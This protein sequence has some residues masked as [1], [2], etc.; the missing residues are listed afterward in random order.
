MYRAV[1]LYI[2]QN[3]IEL[4]DTEA[5]K[6]MLDHIKIDLIPSRQRFRIDLGGVD[7]TERITH[8][9]VSSQVSEVAALS[10]VRKRMVH[11]QQEIGKNKGV[12]MDGRDIGTVVYPAAELKLF[13][14]ANTEIRAMRRY[15]ELKA[16]NIEGS[17]D[18]I[19][20]NLSHRD[21]IDSTRL[22]SPLRQATDAVL[23]DNSFMSIEEQLFLAYQ[24]YLERI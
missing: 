4:S 14:T 22:D 8:L 20:Q 1:T 10:A 6:K 13:V 24:F 11:I 21:H 3:Q 18:E 7:V 9:D 16:K 17:L 5:V 2:I 15:N 19:K 23:I 12:V